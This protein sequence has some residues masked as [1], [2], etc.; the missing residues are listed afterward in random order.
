[1]SHFLSKQII[2]KQQ[3]YVFIRDL[4]LNVSINL[5]HMI[6]DS[7]REKEGVKVNKG[8]K[9]KQ[10]IKKKDIIIQQQIKI[11]TI[12]SIE[13]DKKKIDFLLKNVQTNRLFEPLSKLKSEEGKLHYKIMLLKQLWCD[14]KKH[15]DTIL[16]LYFN[17]KDEV[18]ESEYQDILTVIEQKVRDQ[19]LKEYMMKEMGHLLPPLNVWDSQLKQ[20]DEWQ[21]Q[22]IRFIKQKKS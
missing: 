7:C 17:L 9:K 8:K 18:I 19:P 14:K 16:L 10:V 1:M 12:K 22:V 11:R 21:K 6:E 20:L 3:F 15:M 5:K 13:D 4:A 2:E